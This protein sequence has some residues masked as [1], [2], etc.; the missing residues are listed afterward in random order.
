MKSSEHGR[1]NIARVGYNIEFPPDDLFLG[2]HGAISIDRSGGTTTGQKEILLKQLSILAGGIHAPQDDIIR[3]IPA[4]ATGTGFQFDGSGMLGAAI[5]SKTRLKGDYL[6]NQWDNGADG[7]MF[8]YERIYV[9]T[10]TINAATRVVDAAIVPE[11]PKIPQ[12]STSPP[13]VNVVNLGANSEFYRWHWLVESG[14]DTDNYVPIMNVTNAIGQ[15]AGATF[16]SLVDQFVDVN[17]WLRGH[18]GPILFGVTDNYMAPNGA[19][20]QHNVMFYF[21]PGKKAVAFPWDCDFLSQA[22]PTTTT[23]IG[24]D[25]AKFIANPVWK[26]LYYGHMLDILNRS[27]NTATMTQWA[28]HYSR[29]G[30]D[31]MNGSVTAYLTPRANYALSQVSVAIPFVVFARTSA[32][33]IT[34]ATPF[35]TVTG[36][37]WVNVAEIRLQG[38]AEPLA[39]TWTGQSTW[40]LQLPVSAGL[41]TYTLVPYDTN[42]VQVTNAISGGTPVTAT[43]TVTGTGAV[44]P[45]GPGNLIVSELHY[46][47]PGNTDATEFIELLNITG[48]TL[49][50]SGCH[51]DEELGQ[52]INYT[53][54]S[55]VQVPAGGRILIARDRAA[56][57]AAY[58]AA[59][60]LAAGEY[61]PGGLDNGGES[62]VLY[63]ASGLEI[64]R[65]AYD[66]SKGST[67][68]GGK[69]LVRVIGST[70]T[71][72]DYTWRPSMTIGGN[73]GTTDA[74]QFTGNAAD[75]LDSDLHSAL[76]EYAF[77]TSDT[78]FNAA[79]DFLNPNG[80]L[81]PTQA[82]VLPN[83]DSAIV[84]LESSD[85]LNT[86]TNAASPWRRYWRLKVTLR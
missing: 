51:F 14:R 12:D 72:A 37:G 57:V 70:P 5:L 54:A 26:R 85:D 49:D 82:P 77:G 69:S 60:P 63:A 84:I 35:T 67:D 55:G 17:A 43:I 83:A 9:L 25:V 75:D 31:D 48:A 73:P 64:F 45:A 33:N 71:P 30:T 56:F 52:G 42:G 81:P 61:N 18:V 8:K 59:T 65:F 32:D 24:G 80:S 21:P 86:W 38:S 47:P 3:L 23:L 36:N 4:K 28:A 53:F 74:L 19:G 16:N 44:F 68:G 1:F 76:I 41:N 78:S 34:A 6:D 46:N 7:M 62:L 29:F 50:L 2:T 22:N 13:G 66:D 15:P 27:F 40:S 10:Q 11:N 20:S 58:P 79:T 39:V